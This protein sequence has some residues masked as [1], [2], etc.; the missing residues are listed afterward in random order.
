[1]DWL[2][3]LFLFLAPL[4]YFSYWM[5]LALSCASSLPFLG[6]AVPAEILYPMAGFLAAGGIVDPI[7]AAWFAFFGGVLGYALGYRI[8]LRGAHLLRRYPRLERSVARGRLLFSKYGLSAMFV[9]CFIASGGFIP[10]LAGLS[11]ARVRSFAL[12]TLASNAIGIGTL[13]FIG[14]F[15]AGAIENV[16]IWTTRVGFLLLCI[17]LFVL[18][19][20]FCK[21]FVVKYGPPVAFFMVSILRSMGE[22]LRTNKDIQALVERH[23][24][25]VSFLKSRLDRRR[26]EGLPLTLIAFVFLYVA[27]LLL[28]V[29][30]SLLENE[31]IVSADVN[32]ESLLLALR[33]PAILRFFMWVTLLANWQTVA[34]GLLAASI[35][36]WLYRKR[37]AIIPFWIAVLGCQ[38]VSTLAKLVFH[39]PRPFGMS[40]TLHYSFP[41]G[42]AAMAVCFYGFLFY[43]A[44]R[45]SS[46]WKRKVNLFFGWI[47][48][49]LAISFSRLYLGVH[50]LSDVLAGILLGTLW[51]LIG[52]SLLEGKVFSWPK[53]LTRHLPRK[54]VRKAATLVLVCEFS[55]LVPF[56]ARY[57]PPHAVLESVLTQQE[58]VVPGDVARFLQKASFPRKTES[59]LG[60]TQ[61]PLSFAILARSD[62]DLIEAFRKAGWLKADPIG[63]VTLSAAFSA[64]VRNQSYPT[65]PMTPSFWNGEENTFGFEKPTRAGSLRQRHHARFWRTPFRTADGRIL[66]VGTASF[67]IGINWSRLA[68]RIDPNIDGERD[69]LYSDLKRAN[70]LSRVEEL[71]FT[72][73]TMGKNFAGDAFFTDGRLYLLWIDLLP[74]SVGGPSRQ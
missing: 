9:G 33:H 49:V 59:L 21:R 74:S 32:V 22:A 68:H 72:S 28:G 42:H 14:Y 13:V 17:F 58:R 10:L 50:F 67:D 36:L 39:R 63:L 12:V 23:P 31:A 48:L 60:K 2:Q 64:A 11:R 57:E 40:T 55:F 44:I 26:F 18:F 46:R 6:L 69:F 8:G 73:P 24:R 41:S 3:S 47:L 1:M 7:D 4:R 19:F 27:G 25:L 54:S 5:L 61:E 30:E 35:L 38:S 29:A 15:F 71:G 65:A 16:A 20:L 51:L 52:I 56:F 53:R 34:S 62:A 70:V 66:Y 43:L 45:S 37:E